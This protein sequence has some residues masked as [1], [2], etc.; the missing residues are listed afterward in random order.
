MRGLGI[1]GGR[2]VRFPRDPE[3]KVPHMGWNQLRIVR[4]VPALAR[5]RRTATGSTSCTP[6]TRARRP[7]RDRHHHLVRARLRLQRRARQRLRRRLPSREEPARRPARC[8]RGSCA[9]SRSAMIV[10]PAIDLRGGRC[11][12]LT[13]GDFARE[14]VYGDDPVDGRA[15]LGGA[16]ARAGS[17]SSTSTARAPAGRCRRRWWRPSAPRSASPCRWAAGCAT[18]R[19]SRR[20]STPA[21]RASFGTVAVRDPALVRGA[22]PR[23]PGPRRGRHRRAR[24]PGARRRAGSRARRVEAPTLARAAARSAARRRIVYTD[25]GRD[26]TQEGPDLDGHARRRARRRHPGDRL[27]R[28]RLARAR[29]RGGRAGRTTASAASSSAARSTP[30]PSTCA[31]RWRQGAADAGAPD[32][33]LPRRQRRAR[34]EGRALRRPG[35]RRRSGRDRGALRRR[36]RRRA[37]LPRHHRVARGAA[38]PARRRRAHR[39]ALLHAAHGRRRRAH[40]STTCRA[41]LERRRRQ[42]VDQHG[43]GDRSRSSCARRPSATARSAWSSRSTRAGARPAIRRAAGRCSRTAAARPTG[44]D[45]LEWA[46]RMEAAGAGEILLT[47]MDRDG[48]KEGYDLELTRAVVDRVDIPVIASGGVGTLEHLYDGPDRGRRERGA[49]GVDLPLRDAHGRRGEGVPRVARRLRAARAGRRLMGGW[50]GDTL[51]M[52]GRVFRRAARADAA[53]TGR[54]R[55]LAVGYPVLLALLSRLLGP[56]RA[57]SAGIIWTA[58]AAAA[59]ARG[60]YF[61]EQVVRARARRSARPAG[62]A[63]APTSATC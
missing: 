32:H 11:V 27:G 35:R 14:T 28:R 21:R 60:C 42:G 53:A 3:R 7:G 25:I 30:A 46:A 57:S 8:S 20:C 59:S 47:S 41:L 51:A 17:T 9:R 48:T 13:Q 58:A 54:S 39:R 43:G 22:L 23:V 56:V 10:Y 55:S 29:A 33:P 5:G 15:A 38:D 44:L 18:R 37:L 16:R 2:V 19:R 6:T 36:G 40:A 52:Y 12:R 49:G 31:T 61:M 45:A 26:G 50:L 62:R 63:S 34:R 24:R 4:R 1:F